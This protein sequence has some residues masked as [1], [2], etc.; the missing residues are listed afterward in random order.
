MPSKTTMKL[1]FGTF[2]KLQPIKPANTHQRHF[3][4]KF[5]H[6]LNSF[7]PFFKFGILGCTENGCPASNKKSFFPLPQLRS[8]L[9]TIIK[10]KSPNQPF[11]M[12]F[13]FHSR[14]R[15]THL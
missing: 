12:S 7:D 9:K 14:R 2:F 13:F 6:L 15:N 10:P 4:V 11:K 1:N 8:A 3:S 5:N